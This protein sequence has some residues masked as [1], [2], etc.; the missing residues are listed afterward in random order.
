MD[1][2]IASFG[3]A[4]RPD[5]VCLVVEGEIDLSCMY[6]F[7]DAA[8]KLVVDADSPAVIDLTRVTFFN[9]SGIF[10][11]VEAQRAAVHQGVGLIVEPSEAVR[12]VLDI[13]GL[14]NAFELR[15]QV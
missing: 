3:R 9:S 10:A 12:R 13:A 11:L 5:A 14:T 15:D 8:Y 1:E 2:Q 4:D 6:E 7:H